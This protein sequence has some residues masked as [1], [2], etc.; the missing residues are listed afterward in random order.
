M[1][2]TTTTTVR[3]AV[4]GVGGNSR[5]RSRSLRAT[6]AGAARLRATLRTTEGRTRR[7]REYTLHLCGV[8][9]GS[10][11]REKSR[12]RQTCLGRLGDVFWPMAMENHHGKSSAFMLQSAHAHGTGIGVVHLH[13]LADNPG[14][15][16][17]DPALTP[18]SIYHLPFSSPADVGFFFLHHI[19][20]STCLSFANNRTIA[21]FHF[22]PNSP[23]PRL[24][25]YSTRSLE[26]QNDWPGE[27]G[28]AQSAA[29]N[30]NILTPRVAASVSP[31]TLMLLLLPPPQPLPPLR[32]RG[33]RE[34][35]RRGLLRHMPG[36]EPT[37]A[38][39]DVQIMYGATPG[40]YTLPFSWSIPPFC[41][42]YP[43]LAR[44]P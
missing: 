33:Q 19:S 22:H 6:S 2:R 29:S 13:N 8:R 20:D 1:V 40:G 38:H 18:S 44:S 9:P 37:Q 32:N 35:R 12:V 27:I 26:T 41:F 30:A 36:S 7:A 31:K 42:M 28:N 3:P 25:S 43:V 23:H 16:S 10:P 24:F 34:G 11:G 21:R 5:K 15:P 4:G 39:Q 14:I 17:Y